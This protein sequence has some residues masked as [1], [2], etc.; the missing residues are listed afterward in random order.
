MSEV[1]R[2]EREIAGR[3]L[4]IETGKVARQASGAVFVQYG[5]TVILGAAVTGPAR[6]GLDFF[7]LTVD[8]REKM[9]AA[10]KF[11]GGFIKRESRPS[12]HEI[13][14]MRNID[15]P[16]RPLFP[17]QFLDEVL[18]QCWV[19]ASDQENET[20]ILSMIA[21]SAA[22]SISEIPFEG[23][24]GSVRVGRKDGTLIINPTVSESEY[25]D[26]NLTLSGH[27]DGVNMIEVGAQEVDEE[28]ILEAIFEG[29]KVVVQICEMIDKLVSKAGKPVTWKAPEEN[30]ELKRLVREKSLDEMRKRRQIPGKQDR[31]AAVNELYD[32]VMNEL[33]P[34]DADKPPFQRNKVREAIHDIE[35]E[36]VRELILQGIRADGRRAD[37]LREITC[38]VGVLP[39]VHG[40][41]LFRRGETQSLVVT[42]L[43]TVRDE[44]IVDGLLDEYSKKFMLHYNFPPFSTGE[45]KRVMGPG[46]REIGHGALAERSLEGVLPDPEK[47]PYT[48]RLISDIMESN[49]SSSMASVCGG[50]LA[51]MDAGVPIS[52]PVAGISIGLVKKGDQ[53][54]LLTDILGEED[55]FGDMDFKVSG[56]QRGVTGVQLDLKIRGL[57]MDTIR[58]TFAQAKQVRLD[59]LRQMLKVIPRPRAEMS[60]YAPRILTKKIDPEKIGKLIGPGGKGIKRI[61]AETG[62]KI[63]IEEDGTVYISSIRADRAQRGYEEVEKVCENVKV[64]KIYTGRVTSV[65]DFGA[66]VEL[67]PG[68]DGLCHISELSDGFVKSVSDVCSVGDMVDV[69]VILIDEQGRVKLSRK[70]ALQEAG[71]GQ[72]S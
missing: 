31:A 12:N 52:Q 30:T 65:K 39:R 20:D 2:V 22:L 26:L 58:P 35:E 17:K 10:G 21:A 41:A 64:G 44:Q 50:T 23:P 56:T 11:P 67:V 36:I 15:R 55:H 6:E 14:T 53:E 18:I 60:Q 61:E 69:K 46:R 72:P 49:G 42:T 66:F 3:T 24:T 47:F 38:E 70:A 33:S 16:L 68:Q 43:G 5:E 29:Q 54:V 4:S 8:Y 48:V 34:K 9:S 27:K 51:L 7:P 71:N 32:S 59:I 19:M 28:V 40:S 57:T 1:V 13:L 37:E 62:A 25:S 63:E 45:V